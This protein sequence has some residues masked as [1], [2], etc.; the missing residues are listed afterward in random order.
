MDE[1]LIF[2]SDFA[3]Q[4][5]VL[6]TA[7]GLGGITIGLWTD[8]L[9]RGVEARKSPASLGE[10]AMWLAAEI[11]RDIT[12]P[13]LYG[14]DIPRV[15][16]EVY[17]FLIKLRELGITEPPVKEGDGMLNAMQRFLTIIGPLLRD[18][19]LKEARRISATLSRQTT[20]DD[21]QEGRGKRAKQIGPQ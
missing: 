21:A 6:Y 18:G 1:A 7:I 17:T 4:S 19:H 5:W 16:A 9:L 11:Q 20:L 14:N 3:S 10:K 13:L 8:N 2:L 12:N 15:S